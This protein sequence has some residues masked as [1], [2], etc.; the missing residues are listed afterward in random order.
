MMK[1][2]QASIL[3]TTKDTVVR[4]LRRPGQVVQQPLVEGMVGAGVQADGHAQVGAGSPEDI[5][6]RVKQAQ[7][8]NGRRGSGGQP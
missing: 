4:Q 2:V 3:P 8:G 1:A 6:L 5:A 7:V